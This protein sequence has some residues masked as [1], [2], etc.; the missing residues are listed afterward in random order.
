MTGKWK[1]VTKNWLGYLKKLQQHNQVTFL[2]R[3]L[4]SL[5]T[6]PCKKTR[7]QKIQ[8]LC[9]LK[10]CG[11]L[12]K[13]ISFLPKFLLLNDR[14]FEFYVEKLKIYMWI[15]AKWACFASIL[16]TDYETLYIVLCGGDLCR[17]TFH[18]FN[19]SHFPLSILNNYVHDS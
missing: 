12:L 16:N 5:S 9:E 6:R 11:G 15:V 10:L 1:I 13:Y 17:S 14:V 4:K 3:T 2:F 8:I 7:T 19:E 18:S